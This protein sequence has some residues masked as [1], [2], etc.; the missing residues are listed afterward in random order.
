[1][2]TRRCVTKPV[3]L[4]CERILNRVS[5][6]FATSLWSGCDMALPLAC[7]VMLGTLRTHSVSLFAK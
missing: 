7:C 2:C 3:A 5:T 1:M 6:G 4:K